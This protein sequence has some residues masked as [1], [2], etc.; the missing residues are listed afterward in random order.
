M[1]SDMNTLWHALV[2]LTTAPLD[3]A[4]DVSLREQSR[5]EVAKVLKSAEHAAVVAKHSTGLPKTIYSAGERVAFYDERVGPQRRGEYVGPATVIGP[6]GSGYRLSY[7]G[8]SSITRKAE[9]LR[10]WQDVDD[11]DLV[12][13]AYREVRIADVEQ[14]E[15][16]HFAGG[17]R[18]Q[19][20]GIDPI[21]QPTE[22]HPYRGIFIASTSL[23][24]P[25]EKKDAVAIENA[26][27]VKARVATA[28][29][30]KDFREADR[31]EVCEKILPRMEVI[32]GEEARRIRTEKKSV[33]CIIDRKFKADGSKKSRCCACGTKSLDH[34]RSGGLDTA[35]TTLS[36]VC[37]RLILVIA[38][39]LSWVIESIDISSA[40]MQSG[41][42]KEG[43]EIYL[44]P[45]R[46][47]FGHGDWETGPDVI[48]RVK[49][50]IYGLADSPLR[51]QLSWD[52]ELRSKGMQKHVH[53]RSFYFMRSAKTR[54]E[55]L[56]GVC[57]THVDDSVWCGTA[58]MGA[59]MTKVSQRFE[60]GARSLIHDGSSHLFCGV[61]I[62]ILACGAFAC[63][64]AQYV[65][66]VSEPSLDGVV[67]QTVFRAF[68]GKMLWVAAWRPSISAVVSL[69][70]ATQE[71]FTTATRKLEKIL[72][73]LKHKSRHWVLRA[74]DLRHLA[75]FAFSDASLSNASKMRT[76]GGIFRISG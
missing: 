72:R 3:V 23:L 57:G 36:R 70:A 5:F 1:V 9:Q 53:D 65:A 14:V 39:S 64:Q 30:A 22:A 13:D 15:S 60:V 12:C 63:S 31:E 44:L 43:E 52:A 47:Q 21:S 59:A 40:F 19:F 26:I 42:L 49:A 32:Q 27:G 68:L 66:S 38:C 16:Q 46:D 33:P 45:P 71:G 73:F 20:V 55:G 41:D 35:T 37:L 74:L 61:W 28:E 67:S 2:T 11:V 24:S 4:H 29:E 50:P 76:Q 25:D 6:D 75:L 48:W 8:S 17:P 69:V 54:V 62:A 7:N 51:W 34:R 58:E 10:P 18:S 56:L